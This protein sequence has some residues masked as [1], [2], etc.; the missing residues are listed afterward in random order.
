MPAVWPLTPPG[1]K[2]SQLE[3]YRLRIQA[4]MDRLNAAAEAWAETGRLVLPPAE[5]APLRL[6]S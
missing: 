2:A 4:E 1:L 6:A 3:P 5:A